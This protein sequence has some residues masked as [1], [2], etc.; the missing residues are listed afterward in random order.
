MSGAIFVG[1]RGDLA[2]EAVNG[3]RSCGSGFG[4]LPFLPLL[5]E[6]RCGGSRRVAFPKSLFVY[7]LACCRLLSTMYDKEKMGAAGREMGGIG[8]GVL[9]GLGMLGSKI[10]FRGA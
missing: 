7:L 1:H 5:T 10:Y 6:G 8:A 2:G 9:Q 3:A 4:R